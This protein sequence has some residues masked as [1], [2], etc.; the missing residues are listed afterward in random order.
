MLI[1]E[2]SV[3]DR[4]KSVCREIVRCLLRADARSLSELLDESFELRLPHGESVAKEQW[5]QLLASGEICYESLSMEASKIHFYDRQVAF[6]TG[7]SDVK[8]LWR[9]QG[10]SGRHVYTALYVCKNAVWK[11]VALHQM[12]CAAKAAPAAV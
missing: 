9:G 4:V 1:E 3:E 7:M 8:K 6:L 10:V 5:L 2:G 11:M 12:D